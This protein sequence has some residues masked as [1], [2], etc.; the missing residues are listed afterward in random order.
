ML[1]RTSPVD[2]ELHRIWV[3]LSDNSDGYI[4]SV[5]IVPPVPWEMLS[6]RAPYR[7][8]LRLRAV[9]LELVRLARMLCLIHDSSAKFGSRNSP[10]H[11]AKATEEIAYK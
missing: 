11:D 6:N 7:N 5:E 4:R 1:L 3:L 8:L 2:N 9:A 10:W